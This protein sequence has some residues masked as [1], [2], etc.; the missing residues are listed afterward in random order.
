MALIS[1]HVSLREVLIQK[2][3]SGQKFN[4]PKKKKK[5]QKSSQDCP[6]A[7]QEV[8]PTSQ[9]RSERLTWLCAHVSQKLEEGGEEGAHVWKAFGPSTAAPLDL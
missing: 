4:S 2:I 1:M 6:V 9:N 5:T 8:Q 7:C 3:S